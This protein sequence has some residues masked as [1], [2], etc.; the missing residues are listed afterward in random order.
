M[1]LKNK[2]TGGLLFVLELWVY[3]VICSVGVQVANWL[4]T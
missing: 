1:E 4:G 3:A 2:I